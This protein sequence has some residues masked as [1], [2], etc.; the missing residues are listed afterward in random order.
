MRRSDHKHCGFF[1]PLPKKTWKGGELFPICLPTSATDACPICHSHPTQSEIGMKSF[2]IYPKT[3]KDGSSI[4]MRDD[5]VCHSDNAP[6]RRCRKVPNLDNA[7]GWP[8]WVPPLQR[9]TKFTISTILPFAP[10]HQTS[11]LPRDKDWIRSSSI[12]YI[13]WAHQY[14]Y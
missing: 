8:I 11:Q 6:L 12:S 5:Q 3:K 2:R 14:K 13:H 9:C 10:L 7:P 4:Q 1:R